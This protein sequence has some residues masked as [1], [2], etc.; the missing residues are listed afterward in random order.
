M[1]IDYKQAKKIIDKSKQDSIPF[2]V[3]KGTNERV[4]RLIN[5]EIRTI[6][7]DC[8]VLIPSS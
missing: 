3:G 8:I 2:N 6:K 1:G 5:T 4:Y 7:D